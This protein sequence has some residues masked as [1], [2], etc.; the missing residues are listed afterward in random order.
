VTNNLNGTQT[1]LKGATN[2]PLY[3]ALF[4]VTPGASVYYSHSTNANG[5]L[6]NGAA[7][8]QEGKQDE[9]GVKTEF[10]NQR[11]SITASHFDITQ[12]NIVT[13]NPSYFIDPVNNPQNFKADLTNKGYEIDVVGGITKNL[14]ILG[15]FTDMKLRDAFGR[16]RRN[17]PDTT[18]NAMLKYGFSE[19]ALKGASV[20]AGV[21]HVGNQAGEDPSIT[22][23]ALGVVAQVSFY[24]PARTIY[25]AGAS[26]ER[27]RYRLNLNID[28]VTDEETIWQPSGRFSLSPYP[29]LNV[30]LTTTYTF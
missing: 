14:T 21:T 6:F 22:A 1:L 20:F 7:L 19:G 30:R 3:G 10:F 11:L 29:G 16:R 23:T 24:S 15:S 8:F 13:P 17:I 25:N 9:F 26:Y 5:V 27:G 18:L 12:N 4:K 28:N 2:T